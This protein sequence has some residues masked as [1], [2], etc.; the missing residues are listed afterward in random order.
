MSPQ[1]ALV[2]V[3]G[4]RDEDAL[5]EPPQQMT[6]LEDMSEEQTNAAVSPGSWTLKYVGHSIMVCNGILL[7]W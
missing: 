3:M 6:F 4:S 1:G 7:F 2:V 5:Q